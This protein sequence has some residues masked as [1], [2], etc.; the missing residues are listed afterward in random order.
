[1]IR[2]N[3]TG[4]IVLSEESSVPLDMNRF[5]RHINANLKED[6]MEELVALC[7]AGCKIMEEKLDRAI[8]RKKI[9]FTAERLNPLF[10]RA[11]FINLE[12]IS[13]KDGRKW[14]TLMKDGQVAD[15]LDENFY[16]INYL[17]EEREAMLKLDQ[18]LL[19]A[20]VQN[21]DFSDLFYH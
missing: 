10:P 20:K 13:I 6:S 4:I 17:N 9:K 3:D 21:F 16:S 1:M 5:V 7:R 14:V 11:P 19:R 8:I 15:G 2:E 12:E 18:E